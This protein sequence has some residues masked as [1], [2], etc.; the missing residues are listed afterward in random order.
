MRQ[1][2]RSGKI[3]PVETPVGE[4]SI[5][6]GCVSDP[7]RVV[8]HLLEHDPVCWLPGLDAWLVTRHEDVRLL[9]SEPRITADPRIYERYRA[10]TDPRVTRWVSEMP[11]RSTTS[12]G[13]SSGRRLV[14]AAL[15]PR[16]VAR[17]ETCVRDVIEQIVAPLR[18]RTDVVDLIEEFAVPVSTTA[19]GRIL[20][21]PPKERGQASLPPARSAR[22]RNEPAS[23]AGRVPTR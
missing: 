3:F 1:A 23:Q 19:I 4:P 21:I 10:P 11:F 6:S 2:E 20:G 9:H 5:I 22:D 18:G 8:A 16:A 17:M 13:Q 14:S 15:T 12:N 7:A